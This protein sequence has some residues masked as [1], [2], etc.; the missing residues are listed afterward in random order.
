MGSFYSFVD[1]ILD[2]I[3]PRNAKCLSLHVNA[4]LH[5]YETL[6]SQLHLMPCV[7]KTPVSISSQV[8]L[9]FF[10]ASQIS[11]LF[12]RV[13]SGDFCCASYWTLF[14]QQLHSLSLTTSLS[15][16]T[17]LQ[18]FRIL[19]SPIPHV[20]S[21]R[22]V[23]VPGHRGLYFEWIGRCFSKGNPELSHHWP[24]VCMVIMVAQFHTLMWEFETPVLISLDDFQHLP[25]PCLSDT[26]TP[27]FCLHRPGF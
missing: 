15:M 1:I 20:Q 27:L 16:S 4:M 25:F 8:W 17:K 23:W 24:P 22:L 5:D 26:H 18:S 13:S 21:I 6:H 14:L 9:A 7:K 3:H 11:H 19:M 12:G 2:D 10:S